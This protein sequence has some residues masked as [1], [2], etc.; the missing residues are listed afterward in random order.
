MRA[1]V[2]VSL[3]TAVPAAFPADEPTS[4]NN[5]LL[6]R[7]LTRYPEADANHDG[8]LTESEARAYLKQ[9][10]PESAPKLAR[11]AKA[12]SNPAAA[13]A[14]TH[15]DVKYGPYDRN[16]LDIWLAKSDKPTPVVVFIHG[17]GFVSGDKSIVRGN[18][19]LKPCLANGV[20]VAAINYRYRTTAPIQDVLRDCARAVQF[21]RHNA[22]EWNI[23]K[24]RVAAC[25]GSAGAGT[26][27]WLG[28][29]D[30][31]ADPTNP[32]PVLRESTRLSCAGATSCQFSYD[33][34]RWESLLG[35]DA[36]RKFG[37]DDDAPGFYGLKTMADLTTPAGEKIRADCD[38]LGL[39]TR[40]DAPV[41]LSSAMRGGEITDRGQYL[42]HPLHAKAIYDRCRELGIPV[43]AH[44]PALRIEPAPDQPRDLNSFLFKY[45]HVTNP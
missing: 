26:S 17:G 36:V 1:L 21:I 41:F 20:S 45:L 33:I 18:A 27:L 29:H 12:T 31:L 23:D 37:R 6:K 44:V 14:P 40:D 19:I 38:M 13:P 22:G 35:A 7:A 43:V 10:S 25:G 24:S 9:L 8:I 39:I 4:E 5:Q 34:M 42:H 16:V 32:D 3:L 2:L 15:A 30:D 28:F 11:N